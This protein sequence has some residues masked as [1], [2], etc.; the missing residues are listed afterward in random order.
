[1]ISFRGST[2]HFRFDLSYIVDFH[3]ALTQAATKSVKAEAKVR[4]HAAV[5]ALGPKTTFQ[6]AC[7]EAHRQAQDDENLIRA[8]YRDEVVTAIAKIYTKFR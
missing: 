1:M 3:S 5:E 4:I 8:N 7:A 6:E 2:S